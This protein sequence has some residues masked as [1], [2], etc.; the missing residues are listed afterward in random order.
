MEITKNNIDKIITV[1]MILS[2]ESRLIEV[3]AKS[4]WELFSWTNNIFA[5]M[6]IARPIVRARSGF[7]GLCTNTYI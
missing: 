1:H 2:F 3:T 7:S 5:R 4:I 6:I